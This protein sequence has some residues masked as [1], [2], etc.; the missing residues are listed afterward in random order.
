MKNTRKVLAIIMVVAMCFSMFSH[1]A[2]ANATTIAEGTAGESVT[3]V[4][5]DDGVLTIS[6]T[7]A[8]NTDW[9]SP[10]WKEYNE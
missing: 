1:T 6:G 8:M 10:P 4:L 9:Y 2:F 5:T 3:W 7:G